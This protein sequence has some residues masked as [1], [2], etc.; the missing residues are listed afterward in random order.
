MSEII[1]GNKYAVADVLVCYEEPDHDMNK[2][3]YQH[4]K[5]TYP[6]GKTN[7]ATYEARRLIP[8]LEPFVLLSVDPN[9]STSKRWYKVLRFTKTDVIV[10]WIYTYV[11]SLLSV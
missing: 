9:E 10:C 11:D 8:K 2:N 4:I 6:N 5:V 3:V 7:P 1:L